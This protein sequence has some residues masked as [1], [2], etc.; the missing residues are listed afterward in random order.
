MN[1]QIVGDAIIDNVTFFDVQFIDER[2]ETTRSSIMFVAWMQ[3]FPAAAAYRGIYI[4][5]YE[6]CTWTP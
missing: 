3:E 5:K 4:S 1:E 6:E 2:R